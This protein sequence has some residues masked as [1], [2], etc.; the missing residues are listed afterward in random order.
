M[1]L[2]YLF[3]SMTAVSAIAV[4]ASTEHRPTAVWLLIALLGV[5]GLYLSLHAEF[6]AAVQL[7]VYAGGT[8]VLIIFGVML[9]NNSTMQLYQPRRIEVI[10]ATEWSSCGS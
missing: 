10:V 6:L 4:V 5:G 9:T 3:A 8:L 7:V 2:F 1:V